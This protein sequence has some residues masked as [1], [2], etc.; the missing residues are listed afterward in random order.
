MNSAARSTERTSAPIMVLVTHLSGLFAI[1]LRPAP[2]TMSDQ[3]AAARQNQ[4]PATYRY[5]ATAESVSREA[6]PAAQE[7]LP[8][9]PAQ[10]RLSLTGIAPSLLI[11]FASLRLQFLRDR[12]AP[13]IARQ[14]RVRHLIL[15][16]QGA[17]GL[18]GRPPSD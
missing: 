13:E 10:P 16:C 11:Q 17:K 2:R 14:R 8:P 6:R 4:N 18:T 12:S 15:V 3:A 7:Q 9:T 1:A 5:F